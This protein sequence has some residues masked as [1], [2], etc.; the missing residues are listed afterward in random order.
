MSYD[1]NMDMEEQFYNPWLLS[2]GR[3]GNNTVMHILSR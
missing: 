3:A 2:H 1:Y